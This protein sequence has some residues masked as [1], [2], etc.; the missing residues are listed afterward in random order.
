M[1]NADQTKARFNLTIEND[2]LDEIDLEKFAQIMSGITLVAGPRARLV[3]HSR[4]RMEFE[5]ES[6][7]SWRKTV[8][9]P[10]AKKEVVDP[11][12]D[13]IEYMDDDEIRSD[14]AYHLGQANM[15]LSSLEHWS[16]ESL[17]E[18]RDLV[19]KEKQKA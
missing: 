13:E 15:A 4:T 19:L 2:T 17:L 7:G 8:S 9:T 6:P 16:R 10:P 11:L 18:F 14:I 1:S 12:A 5:E 3:K